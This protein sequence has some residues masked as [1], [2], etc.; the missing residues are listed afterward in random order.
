MSYLTGEVYWCI[1]RTPDYTM[2]DII[3]NN[4]K[5]DNATSKKHN[6]DIIFENIE[7]SKDEKNCYICMEEKNEDEICRLNCKHIFC[8]VCVK[9]I[10]A[11][12]NKVGCPL[13]R[14]NVI[15]ITTK[16]ELI[17]EELCKYCV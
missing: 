5:I 17:Q 10:L 6:I 9:S 1:D 15:T 12:F 2:L 14:N 16:K 13:C 7:I 8:G 11:S 3:S 4:P